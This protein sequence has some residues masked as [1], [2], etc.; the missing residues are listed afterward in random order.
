MH[1]SAGLVAVTGATGRIGRALC[2]AAAARG[3]QVRSLGRSPTGLPGIEYLFLD[4]EDP[5]PI[6]P[7][8]LAGCEAVLH[9]AAYIPK[10]H[11]SA[12][13][14]ERC[15]AV[16][17]LGTVRLAE[18][19][20]QAGVPR[21][22]QT[23]SANAYAPWAGRTDETAPLFPSS[24]TFYLASKIAQELCAGEACASRG[25]SLA[26]LRLSSVY[27]PD[28]ASN[29]PAAFAVRLLAGEPVE[30]ADDGAF[31]ADFVLIDDVVRATFLVLEA[32]REG[33][34]NVASG[35]RTTLAELA[36]RLL[37][38]TGAEHSLLRRVA[39]SGLRDQGFPAIAIDKMKDLGF[40]PMGLEQGLESLVR[41]LR[42][43]P[44]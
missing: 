39:G 30:L 9:L 16:N 10:D 38:L 29:I 28:P 37:E 20:A 6:N 12:E 36:E 3:Y 25:L 23:S 22:I 2:R 27:G 15:W 11:R 43:D 32:G 18:A 26:T 17:V 44:D 35:E 1:S 19:A 34:F 21:L 5:G 7:Q 24:R 14:G 40:R 13:E 42:T 31:G 41:T 33:P 4:L 8:L